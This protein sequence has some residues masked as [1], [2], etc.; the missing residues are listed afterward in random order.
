MIMALV[1]NIR[2][3]DV[4][5]D[6]SAAATEVAARP[7]VSPPVTFTH[8]GKLT[9][10]NVGTLSLQWLHSSTHRDLRRNREHHVDMI[11]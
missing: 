11:S 3:D 1:G 4:V 7:N 10:Q 2:L 5:G 8:L 9:Q 6:L